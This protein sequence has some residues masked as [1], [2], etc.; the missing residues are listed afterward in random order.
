MPQARAELCVCTCACV[1]VQWVVVCTHMPVFVCV[2]VY[3]CVCMCLGCV[4]SYMCVQ[5]GLCV[6][7][8]GVQAYTHVYTWGVWEGNR[9]RTAIQRFH[10]TSC[11]RPS[12]G[13]VRGIK[14]ETSSVCGNAPHQRHR[15]AV[16]ARGR[17]EPCG[18]LRTKPREGAWRPR[19]RGR[20]RE[21]SCAK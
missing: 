10:T 5:C 8:C 19:R 20:N 21:K 12:P 16:T 4:H 1:C 17:R 15:A 6:C 11:L 2:L 9:C 18:H 3:M 13:V 14:E 7:V